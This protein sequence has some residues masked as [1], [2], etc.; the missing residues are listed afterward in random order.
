M[1]DNENG[2]DALLQ[3]E[4]QVDVQDLEGENQFE[5]GDGDASAATEESTV[6]DPVRTDTLSLL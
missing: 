5:G 2:E 6:E 4:D 3:S 1:A